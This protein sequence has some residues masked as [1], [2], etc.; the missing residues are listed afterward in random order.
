M[1]PLLNHMQKK[2]NDENQRNQP[3]VCIWNPKLINLVSILNEVL[4]EVQGFHD[5]QRDYEFK[6]RL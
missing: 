1:I 6:D 3:K 4:N 2:F 5:R